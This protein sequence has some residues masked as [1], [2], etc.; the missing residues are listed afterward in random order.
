M[1][2]RRRPRM[3]RRSRGEKSAKASCSS[4][5]RV[6]MIEMKV[7]SVGLETYLRAKLD[8]DADD[9]SLHHGQDENGGDNGEETKD[10]VVAALVLPQAAEEKEELDE[11]DGKGN[12]ACDERGL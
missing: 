3:L 7:L 10:V 8:V 11:D 2:C 1:P 12:Q 9:G 4:E 6:S 5:V